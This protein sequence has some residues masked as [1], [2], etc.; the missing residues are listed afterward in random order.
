MR[1][2]YAETE[3]QAA[4]RILNGFSFEDFDDF[5]LMNNQVVMAIYEE[6]E[7]TA[8]GVILPESRRKE[9]EYQGKVGLIIGMGPSAYEDDT[10][11]WFRGEKPKLG[12]WVVIR[13][14]DGWR[15]DIHGVKC[16]VFDDTLTRMIVPHPEAI[17]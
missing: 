8:G 16:R 14:S 1:K 6:A 5:K 13:A 2:S 17:W 9:S 3:E 7:K 4:L 15:M 11:R 12:D 10:G